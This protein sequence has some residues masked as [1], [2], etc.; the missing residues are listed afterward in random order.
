MKVQVLKKALSF[1]SIT[2][3]F[4]GKLE[5]ELEIHKEKIELIGQVLEKPVEEPK[6]EEPKAEP[7]VEPEVKKETKDTKKAEK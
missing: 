5:R 4:K 1:P 6:A 2:P 3:K 7:E